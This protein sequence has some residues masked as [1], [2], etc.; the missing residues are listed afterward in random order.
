MHDVAPH[1]RIR[2]RRIGRVVEAALALI[3]GFFATSALITL[4]ARTWGDA[5]VPPA[6]FA[7]V[8]LTAAAIWRI[9]VIS[10]TVDDDTIN[11][12]NCFRN[13]RIL[14]NDVSSISRKHSRTRSF[15]NQVRPQDFAKTVRLDLQNGATRYVSATERLRASTLNP[16]VPILQAIEA[17]A[18]AHSVKCDE[19]ESTL[20]NELRYP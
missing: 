2:Q 10:V 17:E 19:L 3:F 15:F 16:D 18:R 4:G 9:L 20:P 12:R 14:W 13:Y 11:V 8:A 1:T 5:A 7:G 6:L